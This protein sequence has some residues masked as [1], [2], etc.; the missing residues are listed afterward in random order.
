[1]GIPSLNCERQ[2]SFLMIVTP[3]N[4]NVPSFHISLVS[5]LDL[6]LSSFNNTNVSFTYLYK[7]VGLHFA[8]FIAFSSI[9]SIMMSIKFKNELLSFIYK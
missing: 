3:R 4:G 7:T 6:F 2:S 5:L 8:N 9:S 1:M